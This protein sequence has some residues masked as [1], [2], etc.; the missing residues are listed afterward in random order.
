MSRC[1]VRILLRV[2]RY[3]ESRCTQDSRFSLTCQWILDPVSP[4]YHPGYV[5]LLDVLRKRS[6]VTGVYDVSPLPLHDKR[7]VADSVSRCRQNLHPIL[8]LVFSTH[9]QIVALNVEE[10]SQ[11]AD[12]HEPVREVGIPDFVDLN[13]E[14]AIRE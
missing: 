1:K 11:V 8:N 3:H 4:V 10:G 9:R 13:Q 5:S 6:C 2:V 12:P 14:L 7:L